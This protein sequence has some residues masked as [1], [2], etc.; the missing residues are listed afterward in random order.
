MAPSE[1]KERHFC[2]VYF[3][4]RMHAPDFSQ[5]HFNLVEGCCSDDGGRLVQFVRVSLHQKN[6]RRRGTIPKII[7][8]YNNM[9]GRTEAVEPVVL[10]PSLGAAPIVCFKTTSASTQN[11][12]IL[13]RIAAAKQLPAGGFWRWTPTQAPKA[14]VVQRQDPRSR[15][16]GSLHDILREI[17]LPESVVS[18]KRVYDEL[19]GPYFRKFNRALGEGT[20]C[21][22]AEHRDFVVS[23]VKRLFEEELNYIEQPPVAVLPPQAIALVEHSGWVGDIVQSDSTE[24]SA[25]IHAQA[26]GGAAVRRLYARTGARGPSLKEFLVHYALQWNDAGLETVSYSI[27]D[28]F[29]GWT[30]ADVDCNVFRGLAAG[31]PPCVTVQGPLLRVPCLDR[32]LQLLCEDGLIHPLEPSLC[33]PALKRMTVQGDRSPAKAFIL[34]YFS[35]KIQTDWMGQ[36]LVEV[37][38]A[39][40]VRALNGGEVGTY[41]QSCVRQFLKPFI[42]DGSIEGLCW[43]EGAIQREK[44]VVHI[45]R[46]AAGLPAQPD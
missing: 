4:N 9:E 31:A 42:A 3:G 26:V 11:N 6:G 10:Y 25:T 19:S 39:D 30:K 17:R 41:R 35:T 33:S 20:G 1:N 14:A 45:A 23:E 2:F 13:A 37:S 46:V 38:A 22:P 8:E 24:N 34:E 7:D 43:M 44:Y 28:L 36:D 29:K 12:P 21:F 40:V 32:L 5:L 16:V 27:D 18:V 15:F